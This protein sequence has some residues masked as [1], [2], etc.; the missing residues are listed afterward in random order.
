MSMPATSS[1]PLILLILQSLYK[2]APL[3]MNSQS[4]DYFSSWLQPEFSQLGRDVA[5]MSNLLYILNLILVSVQESYLLL[6]CTCS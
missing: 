3:Y 2:C 5:R 6:I 1:A 4:C